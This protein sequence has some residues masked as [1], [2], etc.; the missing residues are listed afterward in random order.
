MVTAAD[1]SPEG[2]TLAVLSY[3]TILLFGR[4]ADGQDWLSRPLKEIPLDQGALEQCE[5]L[6]WDGESLLIT[7]EDRAMFRVNAPL[8]SSCLRFPGE[9][10]E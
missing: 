8:S 6:A 9:G 4:P 10:C 2:G 7:N 3:H 1:L 5:S